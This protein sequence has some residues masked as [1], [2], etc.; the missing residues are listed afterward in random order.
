LLLKSISPK[1]PPRIVV[2]AMICD[3][4]VLSVTVVCADAAAAKPH[5]AISATTIW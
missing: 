1:E 4:G 2:S 3:P 5:V